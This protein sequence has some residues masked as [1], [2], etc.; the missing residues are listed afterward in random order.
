MEESIGTVRQVTIEDEMR[1]SY[2]DYAMS[3]IVSRAL[4]DARD[5]LKP[6]QRRILHA[7]NEIGLGAN[8]RYRKSATIVG[9][10][11]G[12][13]H[14]HGDVAVY[15]TMVRLA[16]DFSMRYQL[17]DGQGNFGSVDG[18][19]PAAYRY[20]EARM[21]AIAEELLADIDRDTVDMAD[22]Y[23]GT[24]REPTVLPAK[25]P[26]LLLNGADGIAV[27]MATKIP[28]H[29]LREL[30]DGIILMIR[31]P[32][33]TVTE[34]AEIIKGPDFPTGGTLFG[35]E[36]IRNAYATGRG[37]MVVRAEAHTEEIRAGRAGLVVTE[38]PFQVNKA[39]LQKSIAELV[40]ERRIEGISDIRDES[41][42]QG[43]RLV[44]ELKR[45]AQADVV[46]NALYKHSDMQKGFSANMLALVDNQPRILSLEQ[47]LRH[48]L[49]HRRDVVGRRTRYDLRKARD[50]VHILEGYSLALS[51]LDAVIT[52]IRGSAS[53]EAARQGLMDGFALS[54]GQA[55]AI[56]QLTLSRLAAL[57]R[58]N[59][60]D[61]LTEKRTVVADLEDILAR[62]ERIDALITAELEDLKT[63][64]GDDRRT[65]IVA[66]DVDHLTDEDLIAPEEMVVTMTTKGYVKRV[67]SSTYRAQGRGGKGIIGTVTRDAD[68]V[69]HLF[70][71]NTH[72]N[73]LFFTNRGR[74]FQLKVHEL[75]EAG[76]T[77]RGVPVANIIAA[78]PGERV[79]AALTFAKGRTDGYIVMATT[80]GTAKRTEL[81]DFRNVRRSGLIAIG[82][83][84]DDELAWV[85]LAEGN[86]DVVLVTSDGRAIRFPQDN[87][88]AMGRPAAGVRGIDLR[89]DDTVVA[90]GLASR[91]TDCDLLVVTE[92]GY[93]KR[94]PLVEY[95]TQRR[96]GGGVATIKPGERLG[97]IVAAAITPDG[98]GEMILMSAGGQIIR[99][100][101]DAVSRQGRATQGVRLMRLNEGDTV[102][103]LAFLGESEPGEESTR[104]EEP[105]GFTDSTHPA[106]PIEGAG[107]GDGEDSEDGGDGEPTQPTDH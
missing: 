91:D 29:N 67:P 76:R 53:S 21:T 59:I 95:P 18:D 106:G 2:L 68:A 46:L 17:I 23:D 102:V 56:L 105:T 101:V 22:N 90:M 86:E 66:A 83:A 31:N 12:K 33:V 60:L 47:I 20:T 104:S 98:M 37:R 49:A 81:Y 19:P 41:D 72:D 5:G 38:L 48:Y 24:Q 40:N 32:E 14:P 89:P 64:F 69:A 50:R 25:L 8:A 75:P 93:G 78:E 39:E 1:V 62:P 42:R 92:Q 99:Q 34:L 52:L 70:V 58:Q 28:P 55:R 26:H 97:P 65:R 13:Y 87:V 103:S 6:V 84:D 16:Q 15:D 9:E 107:D 43:M 100:N 4:P 30:C 3:V 27:G 54:E 71:A 74:C 45:D 61:E 35:A 77:A 79:T 94:S 73:I 36:G 63:R 88:R 82:L 51:N 85:Q 44:I 10:V 7:M 80:R 11:L 96:G 57:E